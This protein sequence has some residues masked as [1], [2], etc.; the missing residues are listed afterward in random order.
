MLPVSTIYA[1]DRPPL[2]GLYLVSDG[3]NLLSVKFITSLAEKEQL[4]ATLDPAHEMHALHRRAHDQLAEYFRGNLRTFEL[5]LRLEGTDF[6][7]KAWQ[8]MA[9]IPYGQVQT[10]GQLAAILGNAGMSRAVGMAAN[11]NPIPVIVPCHRVVGAGG[12]MTGFASGVELKSY[13][14]SHERRDRLW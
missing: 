14:L 6:Q 11:R 9:A 7:V 4:H 5:P 3:E 1:H 8:A 10:Y 13:L 2:L 12:R